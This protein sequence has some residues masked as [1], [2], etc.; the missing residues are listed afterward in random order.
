MQ[1]LK[2]ERGSRLWRDRM[3]KGKSGNLWSLL[4]LSMVV[5]ERGLFGRGQFEVTQN[6]DVL[7]QPG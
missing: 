5:T 3:E 1:K 4:E 6:I 2:Q 7:S